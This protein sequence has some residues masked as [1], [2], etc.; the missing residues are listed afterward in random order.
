MRQHPRC[1]CT[2]VNESCCNGN[3]DRIVSSSQIGWTKTLIIACVTVTISSSFSFG[4][5]IGAPNMYT[6]FTEPFLRKQ[7]G[8]CD[9]NDNQFRLQHNCTPTTVYEQPIHVTSSSKKIVI[10]KSQPVPVIINSLSQSSKQEK[11]SKPQEE[12]FTAADL[13]QEMI[14]GL[15]QTLFII[16][17]FVGSLTGSMWAK[18]G[19]RWT[20]RN[21][22]L[23]NLPITYIAALLML[24]AHYLKVIPLFYISRLFHGYQGGMACCIV[25]PYINEISSQKVRGSAGVLHQF[26]VTVGILFAQIIGLPVLLSRFRYWSIGL[27]LMVIPCLIANIV[28]FWLP[29]SPSEMYIN[30]DRRDRAEAALRKL[31][32]VRNVTAE[33]DELKS[34]KATSNKSTG[35]GASGTIKSVH[36]SVIQL[37]TNVNLRW[38]TITTCTLLTVQ[39][40]SGINAVFFYSGK[41]FKTAGIPD[42]YLHY[43]TA[44]TGLINVIITIVS[45]QLIERVGRKPLII[46]PMVLMITTFILLTVFVQLNDKYHSP[47]IGYVCVVLILIFICAFAVGLGPIAFVYPNEVFRT[48]ARDSALKVGLCLNY[49]GNLLLSL[50]FPTVNA[51][52]KGYVFLI[53]SVILV[54]GF[55]ILWWKMPETKNRN[56]HEIEQFWNVKIVDENKEVFRELIENR[57]K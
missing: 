17:C 49:T 29:Q 53:F 9:V 13:K 14:N 25:P 57:L 11:L 54:I 20:R 50:C 33:L 12:K 22:F 15:P 46:Y 45:I 39:A 1:Q 42:H 3:D 30:F 19:P 43:A 47:T 37:F 44:V 7:Y 5:G 4:Y 41:M 8:I 35:T 52:I 38:Q 55:L 10:N 24:I 23:I 28:I 27:S 16:G 51:A 34:E 18:I 21:L 32:G 40:L 56:V 26:F 31:R 2:N 36:I 6:Q 48:E